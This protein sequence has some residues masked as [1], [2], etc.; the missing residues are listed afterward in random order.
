MTL[1]HNSWSCLT[2]SCHIVLASR[3]DYL[4]VLAMLPSLAHPGDA[5]MIKKVLSLVDVPPCGCERCRK[6]IAP[7]APLLPIGPP[8]SPPRESLAI[9]PHDGNSEID[10]LV[11]QLKS[12]LEMT[13]A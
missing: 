2:L 9:V 7:L 3:F 1:F 12:I 13:K 8:P 11:D 5:A 4:F 6:R 10:A